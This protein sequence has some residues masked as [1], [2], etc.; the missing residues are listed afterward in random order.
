MQLKCQEILVLSS[1]T[2]HKKQ[3]REALHRKNPP[4]YRNN[5]ITGR[6]SLN[7]RI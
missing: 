5:L 7:K 1:Q 4:T 3:M 6:Q 2:N